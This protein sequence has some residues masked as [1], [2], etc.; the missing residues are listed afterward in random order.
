MNERIL[1]IENQILQFEQ[2]AEVL[3]RVGDRK[4]EIYPLGEEYRELIGA[5]KVFVYDRYPKAYRDRCR[6]VILEHVFCD[7]RNRPVD[8]IIMDYKLGGSV[9]CKTGVDVALLIWMIYPNIPILFLSRVDF[10]D[11]GR[12]HQIE[13][14]DSQH[15]QSWLM[16]GFMG[17][18]ELDKSFIQNTVYN[19]IIE[20]L[21]QCTMPAISENDWFIK[22]VRKI[23]DLPIVTSEDYQKW[24]ALESYMSNPMNPPLPLTMKIA[25]LDQDENTVTPDPEVEGF[26]NNIVLGLVD[27]EEEYHEEEYD[28]EEYH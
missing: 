17:E 8:L 14:I 15:R 22:K 18:K 10:A 13:S 16:K 24:K 20:L 28:E 2:L 7:D 12:F 3:P 9:K 25:L 19:K 6:D 11:K 26:I 5:V 1:I 23:K 21:D 4:L 27:N